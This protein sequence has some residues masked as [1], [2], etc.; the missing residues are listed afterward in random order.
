MIDRSANV[1]FSWS[2]N[3]D[4]AILTDDS[5][6]HHEN[7]A[8]AVTETDMNKIWKKIQ[9]DVESDDEWHDVHE[10]KDFFCE[11]EKQ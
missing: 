3:C 8:A 9:N 11:S 7:K 1:V 10:M 2:A 4:L 5:E 6:Y